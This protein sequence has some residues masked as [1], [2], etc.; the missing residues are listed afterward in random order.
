GVGVL[1]ELAHAGH[2]SAARD[3]RCARQG[4]LGTGRGPSQCTAVRAREPLTLVV[5]IATLDGNPPARDFDPIMSSAI[6]YSADRTHLWH[7]GSRSEYLL[8][9]SVGD[10]EPEEVAALPLDQTACRS[11]ATRRATATCIAGMARTLF[12]GRKIQR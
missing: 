11:S 9:S 10:G 2:V 4:R 7:R 1:G 12:L 6:G 8:V 5:D 3:A